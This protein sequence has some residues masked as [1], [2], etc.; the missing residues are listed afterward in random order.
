MHAFR[1]VLLLIRNKNL[2][3]FFKNRFSLTEMIDNEN[4]INLV[5]ITKF[6]M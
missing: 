1:L 6:E 4:L 5:D 2:I 3:V